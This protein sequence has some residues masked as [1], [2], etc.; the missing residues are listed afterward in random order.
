MSM[1]IISYYNCGISSQGAIMTTS[2]VRIN[3]ELVAAAR[4][5]AK[6]ELRTVQG[7]LEYWALIGKSA[8]ENPDLPAGF[9]AE[10]VLSLQE[11]RELGTD[12]KPRS[13]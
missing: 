11:P 12:F 9:I 5:A 2:S 13:G 10:L 6:G 3:D 1:S 7:Q 4:L 8:V